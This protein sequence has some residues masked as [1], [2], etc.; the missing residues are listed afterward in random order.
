MFW[1]WRVARLA[2]GLTI[3]LTFS[4]NSISSDEAK[5]HSVKSM[6]SDSSSSGQ[7]SLLTVDIKNFKALWNEEVC[8]NRERW[9]A[10]ACK[11]TSLLTGDA[12]CWVMTLLHSPARASRKREEEK[13]WQVSMQCSAER[14][15]ALRQCAVSWDAR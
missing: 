15:F 11:G 3:R 9:K 10:Q 12:F 4:L 7:G 2:R 14:H 6:G 8:Q 5:R 13:K 1:T